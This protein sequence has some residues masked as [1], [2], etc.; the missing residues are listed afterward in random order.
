MTRSTGAAPLR[1]GR[2]SRTSADVLLD[3]AS[4]LMAERNSVDITFTDI[5]ARSGLNSAL[6]HY[7]F[8]GKAGLFRALLERD[9]GAAFP[10]LERLVASDLPAVEKLTHHI[11]GVIRLYFRYPYM[12]RL[13]AALA[14]ETNSDTAR[15]M[16]ERFTRPLAAAQ[17]AILEQG[18]REGVFRPVDP[19]LFHFSLIGACDYLF[20]ARHALKWA[21]GVDE[22]D[23]A[24][25]RRYAAHITG[26]L[27]HSVVAAPVP[28]TS[29]QR[30]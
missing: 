9:A 29:I 19:M 1:A 4:A 30:D 16:S 25:R 2:G 28:F 5:A 7:R 14:V 15:F 3:A 10:H 18:V 26:Q 12:N 23:D 20:T 6:I 27:L 8:G 13:I 17:G 22:I 11:H 21:F 24:L